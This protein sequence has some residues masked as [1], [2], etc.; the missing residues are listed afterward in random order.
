MAHDTSNASSPHS[1]PLPA[2]NGPPFSL[3]EDI[4]SPISE[5][6]NGQVS[7]ATSTGVTDRPLL[8][9]RIIKVVPKAPQSIAATGEKTVKRTLDASIPASGEWKVPPPKRLARVVNAHKKLPPAAQRSE[10]SGKSK[11]TADEFRST[12]RDGAVLD[13]ALSADEEDPEAPD[14]EDIGLRSSTL[15]DKIKTVIKQTPKK[16]TKKTTANKSHS[17]RLGSLEIDQPA[18]GGLMPL[19]K[20][21]SQGRKMSS[22]G[23]KTPKDKMPAERSDKMNIDPPALAKLKA[24]FAV[25]AASTSTANQLQEPA[26]NPSTPARMADVSKDQAGLTRRIPETTPVN[27][28]HLTR[29]PS[30]ATTISNAVLPNLAKASLAEMKAMRGI[31]IRDKDNTAANVS[32][33]RREGYHLLA[34][35]AYEY[36]DRHLRKVTRF[37]SQLDRKIEESECAGVVE[38]IEVIDL[39]EEPDDPPQTSVVGLTGAKRPI[40]G[41]TSMSLD[42]S[43]VESKKARTSEFNPP[44]LGPYGFRA[45]PDKD[46][47]LAGLTPRFP[48]NKQ[49]SLSEFIS[50]SNPSLMLPLS[51]NISKPPPQPTGTS[52]S[53]AKG[54][55][56]PVV[57]INSSA[58]ANLR[59][60]A[61]S[62]GST[63]PEISNLSSA[64][65][66]AGSSSLVLPSTSVS[67]PGTSSLLPPSTSDVLDSA[68]SGASTSKNA[69]QPSLLSKSKSKPVSSAQRVT[70]GSLRTS[71]PT[72]ASKSKSNG[73]ISNT[74]TPRP[75]NDVPPATKDVPPAS[76]A[77]PQATNDVAPAS[78]DV[79]PATND[80]H[81]AT[82]D[83]PANSTL[84]DSDQRSQGGQST[85]APS[86]LPP[87][88]RALPNS[89]LPEKSKDAQN[90][91]KDVVDEGVDELEELSDKEEAPKKRGGKGKGK[92]QKKTPKT[93]KPPK[94]PRLKVSEMTP[95][96]KLERDRK[97]KQR[98]EEKD[99]CVYAIPPQPG[100]LLA[101]MW[102]PLTCEEA[103]I[104]HKD[105]LVKS[106]NPHWN[107]GPELMDRVAKIVKAFGDDFEDD[108]FYTKMDNFKPDL[109]AIQAFGLVYKDEFLNLIPTSDPFFK[110]GVVDLS[111]IK[112][113]HDS[114]DKVKASSWQ[115]LYGMMIRTD[116][117]S[118]YTEDPHTVK[119]IDSSFRKIHTL[120]QSCFDHFHHYVLPSN[121]PVCDTSATWKQDTMFQSGEFV[122]AK[123]KALK[124]GAQGTAS[125]GNKRTGNGLMILQK[126]I[127]ETL[128]CC[129][130]MQ[131]A[132]FLDDLDHCIKTKSFPNKTM[133]VSQYMTAEDRS[134]S[135]FKTG[136]VKDLND[137]KA[138]ID[139]GQDRLAAF[140]SMA[141]FFLYGA[142][143]GLALQ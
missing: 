53:L 117:H 93:P 3:P 45:I 96:Q 42:D 71:Q 13:P 35:A 72:A 48:V 78:T 37:C 63:G 14:E 23:L 107:Y 24:T 54:K 116:E 20:V 59:S 6:H 4:S 5:G 31:W 142:A 139:W 136:D 82:K 102:P 8:Y 124:A 43:P 61:A 87:S 108:E 26:A 52:S 120:T 2:E 104:A 143:G 46:A 83:L 123:I 19:T 41:S 65:G 76:N 125:H 30:A 131:Q 12:G 67:A 33:L 16:P 97:A 130:M 60:A 28:G 114:D 109:E 100:A 77:D 27:A 74:T 29:T 132:L 115:C 17:S 103:R 140:G 9:S 85:N 56:T 134:K 89:T 79:P 127:W 91:D 32:E 92:A 119:A 51:A 47:A 34:P 121:K 126:R 80:V 68:A 111:M 70:R 7:K 122:L 11:P 1:D 101:P 112:A 55:M 94:T 105:M 39:T 58:G 21:D 137:S 73:N 88:G 49:P 141:I 62:S 99:N 25:P 110:E 57:V 113:A 133:V 22:A 64:Q 86:A 50:Q 81:P 128:F 66:V 84:D 95:E 98:K 138:L 75:N 118:D 129:L 40:Q 10:I 18:I 15:V 135:L 44:N 36:Q 90:K 38:E 69:S 106:R